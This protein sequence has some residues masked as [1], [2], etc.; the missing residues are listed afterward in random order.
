MSIV[1]ERCCLFWAQT[2]PVVGFLRRVAARERAGGWSLAIVFTLDVRRRSKKRL[3][4]TPQ[5]I[6]AGS[7]LYRG[8]KTHKVS[9]KRGRERSFVRRAG[10]QSVFIGQANSQ[11]SLTLP[12]LPQLSMQDDANA[13]HYP[14]HHATPCA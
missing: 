10:P 4:P 14:R 8:A 6:Y 11:S 13:F 2:H 5:A 1:R 12:F 9:P 3:I 7:P